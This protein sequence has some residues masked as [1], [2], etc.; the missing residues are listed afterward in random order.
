MNNDHKIRQKILK[1]RKEL[2]MYNYQY[3]ILNQSKISDE[4][5]DK[6]L[7]ELYLLERD[8]PELFDTKSPTLTVGHQLSSY[9]STFHHKYR[10]Y[11]LKKTYSKKEFLIWIQRIKK[12]IFYSCSLVCELKYDGVS[13]NLIYKNGLL[14]HALTRGDGK[15]GENVIANVRTIKSIPLKLKGGNHPKYLEIRGEIFFEK[16]IFSEINA[17]RIKHGLRPYYNQRNTASG[18]LQ[19]KDTKVVA[20]R[21]LSCIPYSVIGQNLPFNTQYKSF[22]YLKLWGFNVPKIIFC[23][24]TNTIE[25]IL[26]FIDYWNN[27]HHILPY[28]TD[29]IV[30][31]INEYKNQYIIGS[32][33][34]YPKWAIAYKFNP[35]KLSE[36]NLLNITFQVGRTGII[37]PIANVYPVK[38]S[39]TI[40]KKVGLYN[41]RFIQNMKIHNGDSLLL[42]K[43]GGIIPKL[44]NININKRL[45]KTN[46]IC[47]PKNCPSCQSLLIKKKDLYYCTNRIN[48]PSK[49]QREIQHFVS[50]HGMNIKGIG[51][52]MI[53]KLYKKGLLCEITDLYKLNEKKIIQINGVNQI[54]AH[55][56]INNI[57]QSIYYSSLKR[58][59]Y[60]LGIPHVGE[61]ISEKLTEHFSDINAI[62]NA[63]YNHLISITGIGDKIAN[64]ILNYFSIHKNKFLVKKI[65]EKG[66]YISSNNIKTTYLPLNGKSFVFTGKLSKMTRNQAKNVVE[67]LGGKVF[68]TINNK[69]NFLVIGKNF[70]QKV[71][72]S[73]KKKNIEIINEDYFEKLIENKKKE[74]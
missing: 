12:I 26:H 63:N 10:M 73:I 20:S 3:Y 37:T 4:E 35:N 1:L 11:S 36:T 50:E 38:I 9:I 65:M 47:F 59:L 28:Y 57:N 5:F 27:K 58:V 14:S 19:M 48:C 55:K 30:I 45:I 68:N 71:A 13:I 16:K 34:K 64:S 33:N 72:K 18:T 62:I 51:K 2:S 22:K 67:H 41:Y 31:K 70:G 40:I 56:I 23:C 43:G 49:K 61:Y 6:K 15:Q 7:K 17:N 52:S 8:Y 66:L 25:E 29:G 60:S 46:P 53:K 39:G 24:N 74:Q 32:T 42:E 54:S 21:H 44:K 69:V